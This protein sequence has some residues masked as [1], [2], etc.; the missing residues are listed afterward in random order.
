MS[1]L[2]HMIKL[3]LDAAYLMALPAKKGRG[4]KKGTIAAVVEDTQE[5]ENEDKFVTVVG[6][7]SFVIGDGTNS[8]SD[9]CI[10]PPPPPSKTSV[11]QLLHPLFHL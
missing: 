9:E 10:K 3:R 6:M 1:Q 7:L 4:G 11:P 8:D 2:E 5:I